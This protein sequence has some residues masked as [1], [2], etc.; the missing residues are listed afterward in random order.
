MKSEIGWLIDNND[1]FFFKKIINRGWG[2]ENERGDCNL[3]FGES[4]SQKESESL[5]S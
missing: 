4:K 2:R 5:N 3:Q 1:M